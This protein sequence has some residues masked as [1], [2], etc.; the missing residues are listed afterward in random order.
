M[1]PVDRLNQF[2]NGN[3][4]NADPVCAGSLPIRFTNFLFS[5]EMKKRS[6]ISG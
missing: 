3:V 2:E 1:I 5:V 4:S 6:G